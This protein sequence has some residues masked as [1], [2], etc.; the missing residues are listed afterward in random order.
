[1]ASSHVRV[2][3]SVVDIALPRLGQVLLG[4]VDIFIAL[5]LVIFLCCKE[6]ILARVRTD[7]S[8]DLSK[9]QWTLLSLF[10]PAS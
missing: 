8:T 3:S 10:L 7:F 6:F 2:Q 5:G 9:I 4:Q 1:M